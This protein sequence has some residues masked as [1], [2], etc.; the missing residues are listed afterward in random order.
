MSAWILY[1]TLNGAGS[2]SRHCY[3]YFSELTFSTLETNMLNL[4]FFCQTT[5]TASYFTFVWWPHSYFIDIMETNK[6]HSV[7]FHHYGLHIEAEWSLCAPKSSLL[8]ILPNHYL[9]LSPG[10]NSRHS[11][12]LYFKNSTPTQYVIIML[13]DIKNHPSFK[14]IL[15]TH[16]SILL[17]PNSSIFF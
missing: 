3:H 9:L 5:S 11:F 17:L 4:L 14:K 8:Q 1:C 6:K 10:K 7:K 2:T 12:F 16:I 13:K 15:I